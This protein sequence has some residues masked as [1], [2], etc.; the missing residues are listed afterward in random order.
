M[1]V[2]CYCSLKSDNE[3]TTVLK[4]L[5]LK[6]TYHKKNTTR[7]TKICFLLDYLFLYFMQYYKLILLRAELEAERI[8]TNG[9]KY[10]LI[11]MY[12]VNILL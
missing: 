10:M 9:L 7:M 4:K 2:M 6:T 12:T 3:G 8:H 1:G 11:K 5:L